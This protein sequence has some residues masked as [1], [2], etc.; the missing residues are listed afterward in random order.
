MKPSQ[1]PEDMLEKW[2]TLLDD[3]AAKAVTTLRQ[4]E[5]VGVKAL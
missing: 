3:L 2:Q 5:A 4:G 1:I